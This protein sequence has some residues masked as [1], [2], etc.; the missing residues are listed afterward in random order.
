VD[1]GQRT[2]TV[3]PNLH[4]ISRNHRPRKSTFSDKFALQSGQ[5]GK[6]IHQVYDAKCVTAVGNKVN[7][8]CDNVY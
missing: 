8:R 5:T 4:W 2:Y 7:D 6:E 1:A 3:N